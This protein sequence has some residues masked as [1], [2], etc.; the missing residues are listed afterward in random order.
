MLGKSLGIFQ[1]RRVGEGTVLQNIFPLVSI[2]N[3]EGVW[4]LI[5]TMCQVEEAPGL[6]EIHSTC[7]RAGSHDVKFSGAK[8]D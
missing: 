1:L 8:F 7:V 2:C 3:R 6:S 4:I 5:P